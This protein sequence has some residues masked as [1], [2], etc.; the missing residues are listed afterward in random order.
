MDYDF[1]FKSKFSKNTRCDCNTATTDPHL[2]TASCVSNYLSWTL[3]EEWLCLHLFPSLSGNHRAANE[4]MLEAIK[5]ARLCIYYKKTNKGSGFMPRRW[6]H[7]SSRARL[8][9]NANKCNERNKWERCS[10]SPL[11]NLWETALGTSQR[12]YLSLKARPEQA[13]CWDINVSA[14][15]G[16]QKR[17]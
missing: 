13:F 12:F 8:I 10:H 3:D 7:T 16:H 15:S 11:V 17:D 2:S 5:K 1:F 14:P 9:M 6:G 4:T